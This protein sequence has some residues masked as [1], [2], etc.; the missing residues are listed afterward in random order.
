MKCS[1]IIPVYNA[2]KTLHRCVDSVLAQSFTDFEDVFRFKKG[3]SLPTSSREGSSQNGNSFPA[4]RHG[5][6]LGV[7]PGRSR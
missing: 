4:S 3:A 1:V 7:T 5:H 6:S 2:S